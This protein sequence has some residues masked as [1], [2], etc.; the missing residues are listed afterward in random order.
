M[1]Y[2][3]Y[4]GDRPYDGT[5]HLTETEY[6]E[7]LS[8]AH[9]RATLDVIS[10]ADAPIELEELTEMIV[11]REGEGEPVDPATIDRVA[12]CLHHQHLP[13]LDAFGVLRYDAER[14]R[15]ESWP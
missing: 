2:Q 5:G 3:T 12:C 10:S 11:A 13:K 7:L 8:A 4:D 9:R 6:L 1:E 14:N 15:V